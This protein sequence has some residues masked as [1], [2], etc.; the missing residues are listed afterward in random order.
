MTEGPA[1]DTSIE[2]FE[3]IKTLV[4]EAQAEKGMVFADAVAAF[5]AAAR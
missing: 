1:N 5:N 2:Q 4:A 3:S